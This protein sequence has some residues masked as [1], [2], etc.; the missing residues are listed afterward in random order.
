MKCVIDHQV[1]LSRAPDG[2]L[3]AHIGAFAKSQSAQG[4]AMFS[5]HRQVLPLPVSAT[6]SNKRE[7]VPIIPPSRSGVDLTIF[8]VVDFAAQSVL[9]IMAA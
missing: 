4:Y 1:V 7:F 8:I 2:P 6:G 3:V 5:I 9:P